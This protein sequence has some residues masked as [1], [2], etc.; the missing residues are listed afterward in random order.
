MHFIVFPIPHL[1]TNVASGSHGNLLNWPSLSVPTWHN[2]LFADD[3]PVA[4]YLCT[5]YMSPPDLKVPYGTSNYVRPV[6]GYLKIGNAI[7]SLQIGITIQTSQL[8]NKRP[9]FFYI[10]FSHRDL[11]PVATNNL[12]GSSSLLIRNKKNTS[13]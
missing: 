13:R 10:T 7:S 4:A 12:L 1:R 9:D 5:I 8:H 2:I 11:V 3:Q 6:N